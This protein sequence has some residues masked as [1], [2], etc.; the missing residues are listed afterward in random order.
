MSFE[1]ESMPGQLQPRGRK[2]LI[3]IA[4]VA[5]ILVTVF[6]VKGFMTAYAE[7]AAEEQQYA[8]LESFARPFASLN[9]GVAIALDPYIRGK[10]VVFEIGDDS[11]SHFFHEQL[12]DAMLATSVDDIGSIALVTWPRMEIG[13][14]RDKQSGDET[15]N[16]YQTFGS[17]RIVDAAT[18]EVIAQ[19]L[20]EG[21]LPTGTI[22]FDGDNTG[23]R[24]QWK[25]RD[26]LRDLPRR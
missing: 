23:L 21:E 25:V 10:L 15:G 19:S 16:A 24:P 3:K 6:M 18:R 17:V 11:L 26:Y 13:T 1:L 12:P 20:F 5:G 2:I 7:L 9:E 8:A 22:S 14:Y 4:L